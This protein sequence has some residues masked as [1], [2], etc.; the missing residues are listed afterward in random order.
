MNYLKNEINFLDFL[1]CYLFYLYILI[2]TIFIYNF[3]NFKLNL[4][5]AKFGEKRVESVLEFML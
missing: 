4:A 2:V 1:K 5:I 3:F